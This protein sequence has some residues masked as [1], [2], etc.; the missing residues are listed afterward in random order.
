MRNIHTR[1]FPVEARC[2]MV[3]A[4]SVVCRESKTSA[5]GRLSL[6]RPHDTSPSSRAGALVNSPRPKLRISVKL[7]EALNHGSLIIVIYPFAMS[8]HFS[9]VARAVPRLSR[10]CMRCGQRGDSCQPARRRWMSSVRDAPTKRPKTAIFFPG[11]LFHGFQLYSVA[12][13]TD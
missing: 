12:Q 5:M 10:R 8:S 4:T 11:R 6:P 3:A 1:I 7:T 2:I 13:C 9:P